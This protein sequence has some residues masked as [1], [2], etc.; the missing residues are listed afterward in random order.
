MWRGAA[1]YAESD[2]SEAERHYEARKSAADAEY[3]RAAA[4]AR[5]YTM[6][7]LALVIVLVATFVR[8]AQTNRLW[9]LLFE[10]AA[11]VACA[12]LLLREK[13]R[14]NVAARVSALYERALDRVTG[15]KVQS[16]HRGEEFVDASQHLYARDLDVVGANSLFGML[17]TSRTAL[18]RGNLAQWLLNAPSKEEV[19]GRQGAV[20]ELAG[21]FDLRERAWLLGR[22]Q[23]EELPAG[24]FERW[25]G[26]DEARL[27]A[28]LPAVLLVLTVAW[29]A[30]LVAGLLLHVGKGDLFRN[31]FALLAVQGAVCLRFRATVRRELELTE[32][33]A[34]HVSILREGLQMLRE[35]PKFDGAFL[36]ALQGAAASDGSLKRLERWL[37]LVEQ[38]SKEWFYL[39]SLLLGIGTH[40]TAALQRWKRKHAAEMRSLI[41]AWSA[42]DA[43]L[44]VSAYAAEH[45][46][47]VFPV[48]E[49]SDGQAAMFLAEAMSH[50]LLLRSDAVAND[51]AL[52]DGTQFLLISGSN[53]AGKSTLLRA[54]GANAVLAFTGAPVPARSLR[55]NTLHVGA[56]L[57]LS[58]SLAEG[59]S[60][61]L[62]EVE[63]LRGI[64]R[65]A[66]TG[67]GGTL[68]LIDE[69]LSGTNSLDRK[70]AAEAVVRSLVA[71]GA[72]GAVSTHDLTLTA[73]ADDARMRGRNVHMASPDA[74][75]PLRFDYKLKDGV[76][77]T[78]NALAIVRML[79]LAGNA[80]AS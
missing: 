22:S 32:K 52:G 5:R 1:S 51:V 37:E 45:P 11:L 21:S 36:C 10:M 58:D 47:N 3:A 28:W 9:P 15:R 70:A 77:R 40:A 80:I 41:A 2:V 62:A 17:A 64:V 16:G 49:A 42:F 18:G 75:D 67:R 50:P 48:V 26:A 63:R 43:V 74:D 20:R 27:P 14:S 35:Q 12:V 39:P 29:V 72:V 54:M 38:R 33:L 30:V 73:L 8:V 44:A 61:F 31:V 34:A 13:R 71:A 69:I 59:R 76:N 66:E 7:A 65:L 55:M 6:I 57:A 79:G 25:L 60:K 4:W 53:M 78:T 46:E 24:S 19:E 56:S 68:F 23:F